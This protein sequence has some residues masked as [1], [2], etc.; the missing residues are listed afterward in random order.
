MGASVKAKKLNIITFYKEGSD[1]DDIREECY[2][3]PNLTFISTIKTT[4]D[5][6]RPAVVFIVVSPLIFSFSEERNFI[7]FYV[8]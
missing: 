3:F 4:I 7:N 5:N 2:L 6:L 8:A 1:I